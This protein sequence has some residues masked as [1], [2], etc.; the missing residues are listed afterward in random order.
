MSDS[1]LGIERPAALSLVFFTALAIAACGGDGAASSGAGGTGPGGTTTGAGAG[2]PDPGSPHTPATG[3]HD[4]F[5]ACGDVCAHVVDDWRHCGQC[6]HTCQTGEGCV[7]GQCVVGQ[8]CFEA[9]AVLQCGELCTSSYGDADHCGSCDNHCGDVELCVDTA[10][11]A[12]GGDG[13]SCASP[14][15]WD[16]AAEE[17][18]GFRFSSA[19]TVPHTFT[20]GPLEPVPTRWFRFTATKSNTRVE[21]RSDQTDD[22]ILEVFSSAAC[23]A[24]ALVGCNDNRSGSDTDPELPITTTE[25]ATLYV[26]VGVIGAWSGEPAQIHVDH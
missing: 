1:M 26:A 23:D 7:G 22:Y 12:G 9:G 11:A 8:G 25:G 2:I 21:I 4:G 24:S 13:T 10:C 6:D 5:T 14:L 19:L 3:C 18:A 16:V 15:F 20:C 17:T